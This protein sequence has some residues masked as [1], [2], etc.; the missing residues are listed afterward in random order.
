MKNKVQP[1]KPNA[2]HKLE[3]LTME[4]NKLAKQNEII[5]EEIDRIANLVTALGKRL[6]AIIKAGDEGQSIN[7]KI[8]HSI[9]VNGEATMMAAKT[10]ALVDAKILKAS[11][12]GIVE[13]NSFV[14]LKELNE[15]GEVVNP[16]IQFNVQSEQILDEARQLLIGKKAGEIFNSLGNT[17]KFEV[18]EVYEVS[19][20]I[21]KEEAKAE[22][23]AE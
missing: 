13:E 2:T 3:L 6:N 10:K 15:A 7:S 12:S 9:L 18:L 4:V 23:Q 20:E 19:T 21:G 1:A 14:I 11:E 17:N 22:N 16:R 8:V 5:A